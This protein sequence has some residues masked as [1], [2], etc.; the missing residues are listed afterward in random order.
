MAQLTISSAAAQLKTIVAVVG[1]DTLIRE[2]KHND[3]LRYRTVLL[4]GQTMY[5]LHIRSNK[6]GRSVRTEDNYISLL[7]SILRFAHRTGFID[8]KAYV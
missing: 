8:E 1:A 5:A 4:E 6:I 2:I 3:M 7:C